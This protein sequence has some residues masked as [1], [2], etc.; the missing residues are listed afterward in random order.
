MYKELREETQVKWQNISDLFQLC[1]SPPYRLVPRESA[2]LAHP[3]IR[4]YSHHISKTY[5]NIILLS[6][7]SPGD[8]N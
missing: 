5:F 7:A 8:S 6:S 4:P 1:F 3:L 2:R